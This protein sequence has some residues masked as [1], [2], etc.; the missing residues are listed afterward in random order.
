MT[1]QHEDER[2]RRWEREQAEIERKADALVLS[3]LSAMMKAADDLKSRLRRDTASI[4]D[5]YRRTRQGLESDISLAGA[6]R[7]R[8]RREAENERDAILKEAR[9]R[10]REIVAEAECERE[11]L[12]AD[13]QA[14]DARLRDLE[15]QRPAD[16]GG[17]VDVQAGPSSAAPSDDESGSQPVQS[18]GV[19]DTPVERAAIAFDESGGADAEPTTAPAPSTHADPGAI[20]VSPSDLEDADEIAAMPTPSVQPAPLTAP[21]VPAAPVAP[22]EQPVEVAPSIAAILTSPPTHSGP[23]P[24][25]QRSTPS[26][27]LPEPTQPRQTWLVI[28]GVP[29][30]Q[31]AMALERAVSD[32]ASGGDVEI[33]EFEHGRLVLTVVVADLTVLATQLVTASPASLV[34]DG[35]TGDRA[36]FR[37]V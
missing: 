18:D 35:T 13:L 26:E 17:D 6:E 20:V 36:T 19:D 11:G 5:A 7:Q 24:S 33:E 21:S 29:G 37:Y 16:L 30:Y 15:G 25:A 22:P 23:P 34:F 2:L 27:P 4:L 12:L 1:E 32:L 3:T 8:L 31:Q 9:E 10:A 14:R 28:S